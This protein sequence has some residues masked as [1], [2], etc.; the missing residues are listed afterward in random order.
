MTA[1]DQR[2]GASFQ[3]CWLGS[4]AIPSALD[5][6][7]CGWQLNE[8]C[9]PCPDCI[10]VVDAGNFDGVAWTR[11]LAANP[12]E[13]RRYILVTGVKRAS[14]RAW[15]LQHGFGEV[16]SDTITIEELG[17]RARRTAEFTHWLPR[18]RQFGELQLDLLAREAY[19]DEKPLNLNPREFALLWRLSDSPNRP[20]SKQT[21]IHDVWRMGFVPETNSIAVHMSR[22]RRKLSFGGL[23]GV[24]ETASEGGYCLRVPEE[25]RDSAGSEPAK[26]SSHF[27]DQTASKDLNRMSLPI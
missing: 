11:V 27:S 5:L 21:L 17:A 10:G 4:T 23:K 14:E 25:E 26:P 20:V 19:S 8:G 12:F 18:Q 6:R 24:I 16:V 2:G 1:S 3:F 13:V 9:T 22:L 15:L 7:R